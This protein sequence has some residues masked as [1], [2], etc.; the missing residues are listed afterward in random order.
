MALCDCPECG[1]QVST[2]AVS[3]PGCG[4]G[5]QGKVC[6]WCGRSG[7]SIR[8]VQKPG[9]LYYE[10]TCGGVMPADEETAAKFGR[11]PWM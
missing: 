3:C 11:L 1:R 6:R 5:I 10:C 2:T 7:Y 8:K 4:A 9:G